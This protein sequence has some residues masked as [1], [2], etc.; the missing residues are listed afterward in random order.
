MLYA[1]CTGTYIRV[2][3]GHRKRY[4][5]VLHTASGHVLRYSLNNTKTATLARLWAIRWA[6]RVNIRMKGKTI[7]SVPTKNR[8]GRKNIIFEESG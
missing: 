7:L 2:N 4:V 3:L 1:Y 6:K 5:P 8:D